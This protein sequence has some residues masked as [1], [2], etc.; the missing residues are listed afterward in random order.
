M[1]VLDSYQ[2]E[3]YQT[4]D[5]ESLV[6]DIYYNKTEANYCFC[7]E[8]SEEAEQYPLEDLLEQYSLVTTDLYGQG[9][10]IGG[11][12]KYLIEVETGDADKSSFIQ[13]LNFSTILNKEIVNYVKGNYECLAEKRA[14]SSFYINNSKIEVPILAYRNDQSGMVSFNNRYPEYQLMNLFLGEKEYYFD[15]SKGKAT[16]IELRDDRALMIVKDEMENYFEYVFD[17]KGFKE[18][19]AVQD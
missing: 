19:Q 9:R 14:I 3:K 13:L 8:V 4:E 5:Y 10:G 1:K 2:L 7:F 11:T 16:F 6:Y 17:L 12:T 15:F 18:V